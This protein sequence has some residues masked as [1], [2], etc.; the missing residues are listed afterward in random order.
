MSYYISAP[1]KNLIHSFSQKDEI[2]KDVSKIKVDHFV[3]QMAFFYEKLRNVVDYKDKHLLRRSAVERILRRRITI[4]KNKAKIAENLVK[5]L[6]WAKYLENNKLPETKILEVQSIINKYLN[7]I[8]AT[9]YA[10]R[11][12]KRKFIDWVMGVASCE[13]EDVLISL[14]S[15][16][17][18]VE[19]MF[20]VMDARLKIKDVR[21]D[22]ATKKI[23]CYIAIHRTLIK[24]DPATIRYFMFKLAYREWFGGTKQEI[25]NVAR[26]I[27]NIQEEI[28]G[29]LNNKLSFRFKRLMKTYAPLF[30]ILRDVVADNI[31][32]IEEILNDPAAFQNEIEK[33]A[34]QKYKEVKSNLRRA[35][36]RSII[37]LFITKMLL[38]IIIEVPVDLYWL[39]EVKW[40]PIAINI[41]FPL[42]IMLI[43]ALFTR[44]PGKKNTER[45]INGIK[46]IVYS[47]RKQTIIFNAHSSYVRSKFL[48]W[49]FKFSYFITFLVSFGLVGYVLYMLDF[50]VASAIVFFMF[51]TLVSFFGFRVREGAKEY[52]IPARKD[53][54]LR[55]F[56]DL[57]TLPILRAGRWISQEFSKINV[58]VFV[59][60]FLIE[61]PF[62]MLIELGEQ[63]LGF[64][65]EKREEII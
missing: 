31:N 30:L 8:S 41:A 16:G 40:L 64:V 36:L 42:F 3:S 45:I 7:L 13:I 10:K 9:T 5:E 49:F 59:F 35:A 33:K 47:D 58:F 22:D 55:L 25:E 29:Y 20:Q 21:L 65:R 43:V 27:K 37:Y 51:L 24:S 11:R 15:V 6:I 61:A 19:T 62:K 32:G 52:L 26:N 23:L 39:K 4:D 17:A 28:E 44:V 38:A 14:R 50:N 63:W 46:S 12:D 1:V 53:S 2:P 57:Y 60:D 18:I 48:S 34:E 56:F 54:I